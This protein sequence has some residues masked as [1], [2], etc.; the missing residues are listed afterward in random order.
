MVNIFILENDKFYKI[1]GDI[2]VMYKEVRG[3]FIF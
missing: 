3:G 1:Y 2:N